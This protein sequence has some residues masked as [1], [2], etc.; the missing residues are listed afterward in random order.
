MKSALKESKK[1]A[2]MLIALLVLGSSLSFAQGTAPS[3]EPLSKQELKELVA[4]AKT[5]ADHQK[6]STYYQ[7]KAQR[8]RA[9]SQEFS[10]QADKMKGQ[11]SLESKQGISC[12]CE[13]HYRYFANLYAQQA[14]DAEVL[15]AKQDTLIHN[16]NAQAQK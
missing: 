11:P 8:L 1:F 2:A 14:Q 9:K 13:A 5:S 7:D 15:A 4:N 6:L 12:N 3:T 16:D 10:A